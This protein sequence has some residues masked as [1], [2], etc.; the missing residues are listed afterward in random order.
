MSLRFRFF[1]VAALL[2]SALGIGLWIMVASLAG[3]S[4]RGIPLIR[5]GVAYAQAGFLE[6]EA[7]MAGYT[8]MNWATSVEQVWPDVRRQFSTVEKET[9]T[10]I[11]GTFRLSDYYTWWDPHVY[12]G[13]DGWLVMYYPKTWAP[14]L[15]IDIKGSDPST[16]Q[17]V[18]KR[19][20]AAGGASYTPI[21]YYDFEFPQ[22]NRIVVASA[23]TKPDQT[24]MFSVLVPSAIRVFSKTY[25]FWAGADGYYCF[26]NMGKLKLGETILAQGQYYDS[27]LGV[28]YPKLGSLKP[29]EV[30]PDVESTFALVGCGHSSS[31]TAKA[32]IVF[33][34]NEP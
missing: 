9:G 18:A 22:A 6:A 23:L 19:I 34:V 21:N 16:F 3:S 12:L 10:Y 30:V 24:S 4:S 32:S 17:K 29:G 26:K 33:L 8:K 11:I 25:V 13:K 7:G 28:D 5:P 31:G 20:A 14:A 15:F 27:N 1:S 2:T